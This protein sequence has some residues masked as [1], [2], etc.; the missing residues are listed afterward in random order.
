MTEKNVVLSNAFLLFFRQI[1]TI[2]LLK[3]DGMQKNNSRFL[4]S[5]TN[6][7]LNILKG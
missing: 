5:D 7:K 2:V 1:N 4:R 6:D 3:Y